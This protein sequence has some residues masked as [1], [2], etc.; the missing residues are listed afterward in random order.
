MYDLKSIGKFFSFTS[1]TDCIYLQA[2]IK[3]LQSDVRLIYLWLKRAD[4]KLIQTILFLDMPRRES[5]VLA[6]I[7]K[8]AIP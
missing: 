2:R 7:Y 3:N 6:C 5:I 1:F 8:Q 4:R